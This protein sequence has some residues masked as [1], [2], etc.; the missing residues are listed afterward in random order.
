MASELGGFKAMR[1]RMLFEEVKE[2]KPIYLVATDR[3][4]IDKMESHLNWERKV[5]PK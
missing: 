1:L 4:D 2:G 3:I 5:A